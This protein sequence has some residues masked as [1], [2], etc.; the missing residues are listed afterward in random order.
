MKIAVLNGSPRPKGSTAGLVA[1]FR[2]GAES[3]GHEV[4]VFPVGTMSITGCKG[5][6]YCH[7]KGGGTC[8]QQDGMQEVYPALAEAE[9][10]VLASPVYYFGFTGQMESAISRFYAIGAPKARKYVLLLTSGSPNVYA[11]IQ[12]QYKN[13]LGYIQAKDLGIFAYNG[14]QVSAEASLAEIRAF[15][16]SL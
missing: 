11:G 15:G 7:T 16:A 2:E 8:V 14:A 1:A 13:F 10:V 12:A 6:E 9:L 4:A 5:C 3:A